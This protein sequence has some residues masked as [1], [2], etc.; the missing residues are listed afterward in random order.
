MPALQ[1][2]RQK[3]EVLVTIPNVLQEYSLGNVNK[4]KQKAYKEENTKRTSRLMLKSVKL[5]YSLYSKRH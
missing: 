4:S 3:K 1:R 5:I 2:I